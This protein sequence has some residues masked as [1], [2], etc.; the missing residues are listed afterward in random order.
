MNKLSMLFSIRTLLRFP[1]LL[2]IT[3]MKVNQHFCMLPRDSN[4]SRL[5]IAISGGIKQFKAVAG[6]NDYISKRYQFSHY[7]DYV[8]TEYAAGTKLICIEFK[9]Q[10]R[11]TSY[12]ING[13]ETGQCSVH[14]IIENKHDRYAPVAGSLSDD[15][16]IAP[17][18]INID[19]E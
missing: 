14:G 6:Q 11:S 7:A 18:K 15:P 13:W 5:D 17:H 4:R 10:Q 3:Y 9:R 19:K 12:M 1:F 16:V 2:K 8:S